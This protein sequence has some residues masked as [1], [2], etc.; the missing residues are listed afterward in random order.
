MRRFSLIAAVGFFLFG[1]AAAAH[2]GLDAFLSNLNAQAQADLPGFKIGL[3]AQFGVPLPTVDSIIAEVRLPVDAFLCLQL[4]QMTRKPLGSV[5]EV[6]QRSHG[7]GWGVI[8][9]ELGIKPGSP[10]FH[11]LQSGDFAFTGE[12]RGVSPETPKGKGKAK[13]KE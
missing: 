2:P 11:A 6:Y 5:M 4:G 10:D 12:P 9:K 13:G 3:S 7:K 1:S 8:A